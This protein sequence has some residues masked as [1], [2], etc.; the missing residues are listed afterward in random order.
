MGGWVTQTTPQKTRRKQVRTG[1]VARGGGERAV[2]RAGPRGVDSRR[3]GAGRAEGGQAQGRAKT[4]IPKIHATA[5][6]TASQTVTTTRDKRHG[7]RCRNDSRSCPPHGQNAPLGPDAWP[8]HAPFYSM[9]WRQGADGLRP[10]VQYSGVDALASPFFP[11]PSISLSVSLRPWSASPG[12]P[13]PRTGRRALIWSAVP[14][15]E[16]RAR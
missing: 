8:M 12:S 9:R 5:S 7:V 16:R 14:C 13:V 4:K 10:V 1:C 11:A 3:G 6:A 15:R 2:D